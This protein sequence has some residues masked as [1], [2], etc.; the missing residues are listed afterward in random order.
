MRRRYLYAAFLIVLMTVVC[1]KDKGTSPTQPAEYTFMFDF[2]QG[3]E[4]WTAGFADYPVGEEVFHELTS[5]RSNLPEPLDQNTYAMMIS[6]NNH[7]DDLFMFLKKHITGVESNTTYRV[8]IR[9]EVASQYPE[10]IPGVGGG[11]GCSVWVK[12]GGT[13]TEP[14]PVVQDGF[15]RMNI[16]KGN[17]AGG[18]EDMAMVGSIGIAG[19]DFVYTLIQ[20]DNE[21]QPIQVQS[22]GN[23]ELWLIVGTDS[24]FEATTTIYY[25][26]IDV[27]IYEA[28]T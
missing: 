9:V 2:S 20:R 26:I 3:E 23:G 28:D 6:G 21:D 7:S 13:Q 8:V 5:G 12:V 4:G 24:G 18:G 1:K 14:V 27:R 19:D 17:Q 16:D 15:Y 25:N 22:N 10:N 11:P